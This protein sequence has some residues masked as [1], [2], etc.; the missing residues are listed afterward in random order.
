MS[1]IKQDGAMKSRND[2]EEISIRAKGN[3][4]HAYGDEHPSQRRN[5]E[6]IFCDVSNARH[7]DRENSYY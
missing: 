6:G 4:N 5:R 3:K 1:L 7:S 2:E